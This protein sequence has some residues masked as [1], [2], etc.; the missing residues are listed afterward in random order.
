[1]RTLDQLHDD[2]QAL[3][4]GLVQEVDAP[5]GAVRLLGGVFKVEGAAPGARRGVPAL[6]EHTDEVLGALGVEAAG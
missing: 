6:G 5:G 3:A 1:M 2:P 4:N